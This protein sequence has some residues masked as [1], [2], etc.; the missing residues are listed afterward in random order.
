MFNLKTIRTGEKAAIWYSNGKIKIVEGPQRIFL[1]NQKLQILQSFT[2]EPDEYLIIKYKNGK[3][4]HLRGPVTVWFDPV[5]HEKI[6]KELLT[7][8]E[9]N[10]A[11]VVYC[12]QSNL[13]VQ[14]KVVRGPELY[15]PSENE[16]THEFKWHGAIDNAKSNKK[17]PGA[18]KF[19]KLRIIPDQM[20]FDVEDVRTFD[21]ALLIIKVMVFFEIEDINKMLIQ[22]HDPIADFINALTADIIDFASSYTFEEFKESTEKLNSLVTYIQLVT[23]AERIGYKINKVVYRGYTATA[24][25][26]EMHNNAIETRTRL[27]LESET[28]EQEQNIADLKLEKESARSFKRRVMEETE[29]NHE[30]KISRLASEEKLSQDKLIN[31]SKYEDLRTIN[32]INIEHKLLTNKEQET[33]L[34]TIKEL[35]VDLT[36]YLVAQYYTADKLIKID[37]DSKPQLHLHN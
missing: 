1:T 33:F 6:I 35:D 3:R 36:K 10:Q 30:N 25:L 14:R 23:R 11:I 20:Y 22:T 29:I 26:Q 28:Q 32:Q 4:Q 31:Q 12:Q 9:E 8:I 17:I 15:M 5:L 16:W 13:E 21:D 2:A 34:K 19:K 37:S 7:S 24:R 27:K 18:L